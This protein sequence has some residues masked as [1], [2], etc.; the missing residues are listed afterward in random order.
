MTKRFIWDFDGTIV[1]GDFS[2][3]E[4]LFKDNLS[5]EAVGL[6]SFDYF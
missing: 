6:P 1:D 2:L 3:E 4:K 5:E